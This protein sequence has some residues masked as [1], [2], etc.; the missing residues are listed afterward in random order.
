MLSDIKVINWRLEFQIFLC[1]MVNAMK[2]SLYFYSNPP[3]ST[4]YL[5]LGLMINKMN[6]S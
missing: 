2:K 6:Y 3:H 1:N 5:Y 4:T